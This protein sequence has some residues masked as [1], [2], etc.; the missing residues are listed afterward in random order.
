MNNVIP[1]QNLWPG[2][3]SPTPACYP[4]LSILPCC[5]LYISEDRVLREEGGGDVQEGNSVTCVYRNGWCV[6]SKMYVCGAS[7]N[8]LQ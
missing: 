6:V 8:L 4:L 7:A 3:L 2:P 5:L 1:H